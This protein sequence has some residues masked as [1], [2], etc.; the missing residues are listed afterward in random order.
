[1]YKNFGISEDVYDY[2]VKITD[3]LK[4]RFQEIDIIAEYN[5]LKVVNAMQ[6]IRY[7][8]RILP[9]LPDMDIMI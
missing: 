5:Q 7:Q 6:K 9:R 4:Q 2:S 3:A 1:M 8:R